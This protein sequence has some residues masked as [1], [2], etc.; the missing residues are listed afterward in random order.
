MAQG[1]D[2]R[3]PQ[4]PIEE[5]APSLCLLRLSQA[6]VGLEIIVVSPLKCRA[7]RGD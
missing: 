6:Q 1:H 5:L 7:D 4:A 2:A 3:S